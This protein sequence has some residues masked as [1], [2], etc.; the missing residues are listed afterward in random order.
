MIAANGPDDETRTWLQAHREINYWNFTHR[1][2]RG[3]NIPMNEMLDAAMGLKVGWFVRVDD[4]C[5]FEKPKQWIKHMLSVQRYFH[6]SSGTNVV[7]GPLVKGL[8]NPI[9]S[10]GTTKIRAGKAEIVPILG[11]ICRMMPMSLMRYF[12]FNERMPM[13]AGEAMQL[14][15][16]CAERNVPLIRDCTMTVTHGESTDAQEAKDSDWAYEH[17]MLQSLPYGL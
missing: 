12:R 7:M 17:A 1:H 10:R 3:Q 2:N 15:N 8:R 6:D 9:A 11:G 4:D 13:G 5:F 14:A 16:F